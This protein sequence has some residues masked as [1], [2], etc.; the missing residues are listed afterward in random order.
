[1]VGA[2]AGAAVFERTACDGDG[3]D[4]GGDD[5]AADGESAA[6]VVLPASVVGVRSRCSRCPRRSTNS[7][8]SRDSAVRGIGSGMSTTSRTRD[9]LV[10]S[11]TTLV[12]RKIAS[13]TL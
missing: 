6:H 7:F 1:P 11:T 10:L 5:W 3:G 9:G 2:G 13:S 4:H 8:V 12:D